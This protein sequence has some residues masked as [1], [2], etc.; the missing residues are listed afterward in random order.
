MSFCRFFKL[1]S[2]LHSIGVWMT[3]QNVKL[4]TLFIPARN[5]SGYNMLNIQENP[6]IILAMTTR[7]TLRWLIFASSNSTTPLHDINTFLKLFFFCGSCSKT[8]RKSYLSDDSKHFCLPYFHRLTI[9]LIKKSTRT[10]KI[11]RAATH[12]AFCSKAECSFERSI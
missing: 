6:L 8:L 12:H 9:S 2:C 7:G 1:P 4:S 10:T 3:T 11:H 5:I